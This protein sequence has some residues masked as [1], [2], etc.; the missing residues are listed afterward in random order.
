MAAGLG[1]LICGLLGPLVGLVVFAVANLR[2][3]N[4]YT[5]LSDLLLS[6][7]IM[8]LYA[9]IAFGVPGFILGCCGGLLLRVLAARCRSIKNLIMVGIIVGL[10]LGS[11][12]PLWVVAYEWKVF[13][14]TANYVR[15]MLLGAFSGVV[16]GLVMT[17]LLRSR[18][19]LHLSAH[20]SHA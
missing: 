12:V 18:R 5:G 4:S 16:C 9:E 20:Q 6:I 19:L 7:G 2:G 11:A 10:A 8:W 17:W 15:L 13:G 3:G 14:F 1:G